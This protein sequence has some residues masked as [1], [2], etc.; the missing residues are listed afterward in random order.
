MEERQEQDTCKWMVA[1]GLVVRDGY[2]TPSGS[3][4]EVRAAAI[5]NM[6][7]AA[8]L[9]QRREGAEIA[10]D[11]TLR[12]DLHKL[13]DEFQDDEA[14]NPVRIALLEGSYLFEQLAELIF[15]PDP[16]LCGMRE[17]PR[18]TFAGVPYFFDLTELAKEANY[19]ISNLGFETEGETGERAVAFNRVAL[20]G[21]AASGKP[22]LRQQ[23]TQSIDQI[24]EM[25]NDI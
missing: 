11:P 16:P 4:D 2:L 1:L 22:A 5:A 19:D 14:H 21:S 20:I 13:V 6:R 3:R 10:T 7:E 8:R 17:L 24:A 18:E 15:L 23:A 12:A 9:Y 25:M